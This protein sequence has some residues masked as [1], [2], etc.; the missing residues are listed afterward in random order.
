MAETLLIEP[1]SKFIEGVMASGG[2]DLKK[3]FQCATCSSVCML[4]KEGSVFPR[5][6]MME[7]QWGLKEKVLAD[8]AIW[9]CHDCGDCTAN[10]PRG[11]KPSDVMGALRKEAVMRYA[12]P[13][14]AG[15][16]VSNPRYLP[17]L[18]L[19]PFLIFGDIGLAGL[20]HGLHRPFVFAELFPQNTLEALFFT[21]AGLVV[22][23]FAVGVARFVKALRAS[24][25][26]GRILPGLV[27][28]LVE[29]LTHKRFSDCAAN[30]SRYWG[31]L[32]AFAGF[33]GLAMMGTAV[34]IGTLLGVMHTPLPILGGWKLFA[35]FSASLISIGI[36]ILLVERTKSSEKR[37]ETTY[38]DSFFLLTLAGVVVTGILSEILRLAQS[39]E[40]MYPVYFAHL[41]LIFTLFLY[42]PY[43]KFAHFVYRTVAMAATRGGS[44]GEEA[45]P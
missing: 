44:S 32:L 1:D 30:R 19:I 37:A 13:R 34:G 27:P 39:R 43:S 3:C 22:F 25:V 35:N 45:V 29:I 2:S 17:L 6:Q 10:C 16:M 31:H 18:L 20:G 41:I 36:L 14:F 12:F 33:V 15:A 11:A 5:K 40:L 26:D 8:P 23:S 42:A 24:G 4:A 28:S 21:V 38:F 9:L 7:A